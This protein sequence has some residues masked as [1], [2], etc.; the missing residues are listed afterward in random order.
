MWTSWCV[1]SLQLRRDTAGPLSLDAITWE[2]DLLVGR[3]RLAGIVLC[4]ILDIVDKHAGSRLGS[5]RNNI[6]R[7]GRATSGRHVQQR[8]RGDPSQAADR[9]GSKDARVGVDVARREL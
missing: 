1:R 2:R 8:R 7:R 9:G 5:S 3:L 6:R 4:D